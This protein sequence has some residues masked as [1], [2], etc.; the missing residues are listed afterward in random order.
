MDEIFGVVSMKL[1]WKGRG[2]K[3]TGLAWM[4]RMNRVKK[5]S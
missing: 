1:G 4:D 3:N 2:G 5:T